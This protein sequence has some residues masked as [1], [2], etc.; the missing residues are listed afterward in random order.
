MSDERT[1]ENCGTEFCQD[2]NDRICRD[3]HLWTPK[4]HNERWHLEDLK[5]ARA[6]L[7]AQ[8]KRIDVEI[9]IAESDVKRT[10]KRTK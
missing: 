7:Q 6:D 4:G 1:C 10:E 3:R 9:T 2:G 5:R 8:I